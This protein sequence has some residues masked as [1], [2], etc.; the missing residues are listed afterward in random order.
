MTTA[1][2]SGTAHVDKTGGGKLWMDMGCPQ[3]ARNCFYASST[4]DV[5]NLRDEQLNSALAYAEDHNFRGSIPDA[6]KAEYQ[7][8]AT[9]EA[10]AVLPMARGGY[11]S[12]VY[13]P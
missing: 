4:K 3:A 13:Q 6:L 2:F 1:R 7:A 11:E 9:G 5:R 10:H 12:P 8:R